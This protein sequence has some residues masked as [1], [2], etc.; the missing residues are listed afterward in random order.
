MQLALTHGRSWRRLLSRKVRRED[1]GDLLA[2]V[3]V[4]Q[5]HASRNTRITSSALSQVSS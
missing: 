4:P 3:N 1:G 2:G 5:L